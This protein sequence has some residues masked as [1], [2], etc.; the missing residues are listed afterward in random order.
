MADI[1]VDKETFTSV[2]KDVVNGIVGFGK[3]ITIDFCGVQFDL[4]DVFIAGLVLGVIALACH[5]FAD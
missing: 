3:S 5:G 2:F 4:W 1:V